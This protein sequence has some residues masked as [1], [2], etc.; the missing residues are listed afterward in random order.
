MTTSLYIDILR[1]EEALQALCNVVADELTSRLKNEKVV[2]G[3]VFLELPAEVGQVSTDVIIYLVT[4][5]IDAFK[6]GTG[7]KRGGSFN[8]Y[9]EPYC[10]GVL[11]NIVVAYS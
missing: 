2:D 4:M 8:F 1:D 3:P 11:T 9:A 10:D 7:R 6:K 5:A